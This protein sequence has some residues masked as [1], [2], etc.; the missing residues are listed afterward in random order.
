M[1]GGRYVCQASG[2]DNTIGAQESICEP[3]IDEAREEMEECPKVRWGEGPESYCKRVEEWSK[4]V[5]P[6]FI[7]APPYLTDE[8]AWDPGLGPGR[9]IYDVKGGVDVMDE[10]TTCAPQGVWGEVDAICEKL[11]SLDAVATA[12]TERLDGPVEVAQAVPE[13][14]SGVGSRLMYVRSRLEILHKNLSYLSRVV[15]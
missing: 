7:P 2:C 15:G 6:P 4:R 8:T 11:D 3:C 1:A 10:A 5:A 12:L 13:G 14:A 9:F